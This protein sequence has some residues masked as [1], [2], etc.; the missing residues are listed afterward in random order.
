M[1]TMAPASNA[2]ERS[3]YKDIKFTIDENATVYD[4]V[5]Q[6]SAYDVGALVTVDAGGNVSGVMSER[7]YV[8][9]VA[10]L[11]RTSKDTIVKEIST[12][13][14]NITTASPDESIEDCMNKMLQ[15]DVRHLPLVG[16][17]GSLEGFLSIKD[18]VKEVL[19]AKEE[20]LNKLADKFL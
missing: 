19:S 17:D 9:K 13:A 6:L 11:G 7:D 3:C 15:K 8:C 12:K 20:E 10:L 2:W 4:A 1:V 5:Q 18:L 14:A 16:E